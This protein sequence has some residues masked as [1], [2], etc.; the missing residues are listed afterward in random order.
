MV[1]GRTSR[2]IGTA[3]AAL[4]GLA[5][6]AGLLGVLASLA[7][8]NSLLVGSAWRLPALLSVVVAG[9]TLGV[10][11]YAGRTSKRWERTPYW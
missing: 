2:R 5:V 4:A 9:V 8:V 10:V 6:A 11:V 7:T 3:L 1:S